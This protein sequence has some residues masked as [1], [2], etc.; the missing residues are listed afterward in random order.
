MKTQT[1]I[2]VECVRADCGPNEYDVFVKDVFGSTNVCTPCPYHELDSAAC[3]RP[4]DSLD[5]CSEIVFVPLKYLPLLQMRG[6]G[7]VS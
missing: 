4:R 3:L 2:G 5:D 6:I 7:V 1:I